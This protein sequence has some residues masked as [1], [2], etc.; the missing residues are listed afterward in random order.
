MPGYLPEG[1]FKSVGSAAQDVA[2]A[3][4]ILDAAERMGLG[5]TVEI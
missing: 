1:L 4:R 3:G 5:A 2:A